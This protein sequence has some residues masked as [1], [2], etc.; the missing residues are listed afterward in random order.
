MIDDLNGKENT[1]IIGGTGG[2]TESSK[3][4]QSIND[5][6][7]IRVAAVDSGGDESSARGAPSI[8]SVANAGV[9][10]VC[11][12]HFTRGTISARGSTHVQDRGAVHQ[13]AVHADVSGIRANGARGTGFD[14]SKGAIF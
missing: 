14:I 4:T 1:Y 9:L 2:H 13:R 6:N 7:L 12:A 10:G 5:A 11:L 3:V 8:L